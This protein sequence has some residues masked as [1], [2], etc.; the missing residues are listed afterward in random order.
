M[1]LILQ[2]VEPLQR[3][4]SE[5]SKYTKAVARKWLCN[6][7][8]DATD[9][10]TTMNGV[11]CAG[12]AEELQGRQFGQQSQFST[13]VCEEKRQFGRALLSERTESRRL[14]TVRSLYQE[15][16]RNRLRTLVRN[17]DL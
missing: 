11:V 13:G 12:L 16:Y 8:P 10:H 4:E 5:M 17:R 15:T 6:H 1:S 7:V 14:A 2:R 9:M 3:N